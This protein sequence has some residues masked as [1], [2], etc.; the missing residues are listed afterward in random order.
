MIVSDACTMNIINDPTWSVNAISRI[1]ID[2]SSVLLQIVSSFYVCHDDS[3]MF[4]VQATDVAI[5]Y[6]DIS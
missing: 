2:Y 3:N 5:V 6:D 4:K 1:V